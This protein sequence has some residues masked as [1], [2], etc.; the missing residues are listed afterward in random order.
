MPDQTPE[1]LTNFEL[2]EIA[3][4]PDGEM[5]PETTIEAMARELLAA[6]ARIAELEAERDIAQGQWRLSGGEALTARD[7]LDKARARITEWRVHFAEIVDAL[8]EPEDTRFD[9]LP[10]VAR[11]LR[12]RIAEL[13]DQARRQVRGV[14]LAWALDLWMALGCPI[15]EFDGYTRRNNAAD[16]WANLLGVVRDI[17]RPKCGKPTDGGPCVLSVHEVGPCYSSGDVGA[18]EPIP[19]AA[20]KDDAE[21]EAPAVEPHAYRRGRAAGGPA[22]SDNRIEPQEVIQAVEFYIEQELNDAAKYDNRAPFDES[23]IW[24]LH[25]LARDIYARGVDDGT[26]QEAE[27]QRHQGRRDREAAK[28]RVRAAELREVRDAE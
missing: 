20:P 5:L 12:A 21:P 4:T 24:S 10:E 26:R 1:P 13:E 22:V 3:E 11:E 17:F 9:A 8:G 18:S 27:R 2:R 16:T 19:H 14:Q 25:Q 6:R 15:E 7:D 23:G 28:A